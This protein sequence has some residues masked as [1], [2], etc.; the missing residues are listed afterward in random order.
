MAKARDPVLFV[1]MYLHTHLA[2]SPHDDPRLAIL[3]QVD[4]FADKYGMKPAGSAFL[5]KRATEIDLLRFGHPVSG[6]TL[7][8]NNR[9]ED[10]GPEAASRTLSEC[11]VYAYHDA[12]MIQI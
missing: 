7:L 2:G 1:S 10:Q 8:V 6:Y 5:Y 9:G 12:L 4:A 3:Q 11:L